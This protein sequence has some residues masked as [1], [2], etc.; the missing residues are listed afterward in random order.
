METNY[1]LARLNVRSS[2]PG[3]T[4]WK[5]SCLLQVYPIFFV[6]VVGIVS[7]PVFLFPSDLYLYDRPATPPVRWLSY[8]D[9]A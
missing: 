4:G 5:R 6:I 1:T 7:L 3:L 9:M 8:D 2:Y